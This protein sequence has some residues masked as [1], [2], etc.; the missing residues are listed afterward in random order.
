LIPPSESVKLEVA[1]KRIRKIKKSLHYLHL[2]FIY[3]G[4]S[5]QE[6]DGTRLFNIILTLTSTEAAEGVKKAL[7][8]YDPTKFDVA[9]DFANK[10][11]KTSSEFMQAKFSVHV[12][13][14]RTWT[15]AVKGVVPMANPFFE[16]LKAL[17]RVN[18][19]LEFEN[20]EEFFSHI[21]SQR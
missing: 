2:P 18:L 1:C 14:V 19:A 20:I 4:K 15:A 21:Y 6:G 13:S 9:L 16:F 8:F 12:E 17:N 10:P 3:S 5:Q 11:D 7:E